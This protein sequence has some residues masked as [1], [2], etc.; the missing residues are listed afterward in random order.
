MLINNRIYLSSPHMSGK[1]MSYVQEAFDS[2]WVA[3]LGANV[4]EFELLLA[5]FCNVKHAAALSSGTA[6]I[7]LALNILGVRRDDYVIASSFTF[8]ATV[9]PILY[10]CARP[11]LIDSE[12]DTWNMDPVLLEEAIMERRRNGLPDPK[13]IIVVHLYGMPA[14]MGKIMTISGKYG[15]P[16]IEDAAE[17][18]GSRYKN[19]PAGSFGKMAVLSFNGNKII[20]TSGGGALLSNE[21]ELIEKARFLATQARDPAPHY[22]HSEVGYNYRMSNIVAGIGRGQM[23]VLAKR[24]EKRRI[25][26]QWY[27]DL[28]NN[29]PGVEFHTEPSEEYF[30]NY[31][32]TCI[33]IDPE[34]SATN[35]EKLRLALE[36]GN[37]ESRPLWKP[38]HLQ[39][40]FSGYKSY[41]NGT[42]EKLFNNG[43]CLPSGSNLKE[44]D[45]RRI[46]DIIK[47]EF[48]I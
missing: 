12:T 4:D 16:V 6:A 45:L 46:A 27:R 39:P 44:S 5:R 30:S 47:R 22:Q 24:V 42:S 31:W 33:T 37:I 23:E 1:E 34:E 17:A 9:N 32:L 7:H 36:A 15:I 35:R 26:N 14:R 25:V 10:L 13:A 20:T 48:R 8:S 11:I 29:V 3:P 19:R 21:G 18:L 41:N 40:V 2:N 43:L 38:M 28:L